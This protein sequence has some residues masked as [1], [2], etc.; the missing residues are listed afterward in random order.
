VVPGDAP[1]TRTHAHAHTRARAHARAR[2]RTRTRTHRAAAAAAAA[3]PSV[4][5]ARA[6]APPGEPEPGCVGRGGERGLPRARSCGGAVVAVHARTAQITR[7]STHDQ[8]TLWPD[9]G[10]ECGSGCV[11][12]GVAA[13]ATLHWWAAPHCPYPHQAGHVAPVGGAA[14][15]AAGALPRGSGRAAAWP[16]RSPAEGWS[17]TC[18]GVPASWEP[19]PGRFHPQLRDKNRRDIGKSQSIWTD[20]KMET[21]RSPRRHK[22]AVDVV[23]GHL[24]LRSIH[25]EIRTA[26]PISVKVG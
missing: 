13:R 22:G 9:H 18:G 8:Q 12:M 5:Y 4:E 26:S 23:L 11:G 10:R 21:A 1:R 20:S 14:G 15:S 2:A 6:S 19:C 25:I 17:G 7:P 16:P 24:A 3:V